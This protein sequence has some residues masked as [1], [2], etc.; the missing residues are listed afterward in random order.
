MNDQSC[1]RSMT[2]RLQQ[3]GKVKQRKR[4]KTKE[5]T[6]SERSLTMDSTQRSAPNSPLPLV[7]PEFRSSAIFSLIASEVYWSMRASATVPMTCC[8]VMSFYATRQALSSEQ[9]RESFKTR[10]G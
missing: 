1:T 6:H 10:W 5:N 8:H 4:Q 7:R 9:T 2:C 3:E